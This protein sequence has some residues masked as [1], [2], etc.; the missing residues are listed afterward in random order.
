[1]GPAHPK[2]SAKSART[3]DSLYQDQYG[4][5]I[6]D[7][8]ETALNR[9]GLISPIIIS[10]PAGT[11]KTH[12][13]QGIEIEANRLNYSVNL[14]SLS[15]WNENTEKNNL[16]ITQ[17]TDLLLIDG[18]HYIN[19]LNETKTDQFLTIFNQHFD[20]Q[21]QIF[22]S[23]EIDVKDL[24]L[25]DR[26]Q[27]RLKSG[28]SF[29]L[30]LPDPDDRIGFL[31]NRLTEFDIKASPER[32]TNLSIPEHLSYRD[33]ESVA[34]MIFL[35]SRNNWTDERLANDLKT[36]FKKSEKNSE[37]N[38]NFSIEHIVNVVVN[39]FS[40]TK[41]DLISKSRRAEHTLPRHIAMT[42]AQKYTGLNKSSIARYFQRS[43]HSVVI[44]AIAKI[45]Q[46][47][48]NDVA[49]RSLYSKVLKSLMVQRL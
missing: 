25:A 43:D 29:E 45:N 24:N 36:K 7:T 46:M 12:L 9:L 42:L 18:L 49:F 6:V 38:I 4:S 23:T 26:W 22:I 48:K 8:V 33:L 40:V 31:Q 28:L 3:L 2:S 10:G 5:L 44:H 21:K 32:L 16:N 27:S 39:H 47:I 15:V 1:M 30:K 41:A 20:R 37:S 11:G 34:A 17:L 13:L 14:I 19:S 35:Y